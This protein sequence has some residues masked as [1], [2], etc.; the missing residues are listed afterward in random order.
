MRRGRDSN[1][2]YGYDPV[3]RFSK[4]A[5]SAARPPLQARRI[6]GSPRASCGQSVSVESSPFHNRHS[7]GLRRPVSTPAGP[8]AGWHSGLPGKDRARGPGEGASGSVIKE[9]GTIRTCR[10]VAV[11]CQTLV[12]RWEF[13][14]SASVPGCPGTSAVC[15]EWVIPSGSVR[16]TAGVTVS[17]GRPWGL[18]YR[19]DQKCASE[20]RA[21]ENV[22]NHFECTRGAFQRP[23]KSGPRD[24]VG[25]VRG[26]GSGGVVTK[27]AHGREVRG[28]GLV[29]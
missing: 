16:T 18:T 11:L 13:G 12:S 1:P 3:D 6:L 17:G 5:P 15:P 24:G 8:V 4:P 9:S 28:L 21:G 7:Q 10:V 23:M 25:L 27:K 19:F 14:R 20:S 29:K 22:P 2:C 26:R